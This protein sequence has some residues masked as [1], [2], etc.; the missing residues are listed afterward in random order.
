MY[1]CQKK[2]KNRIWAKSQGKNI[3]DFN[4]SLSIERLLFPLKSKSY[5]RTTGSESPPDPEEWRLN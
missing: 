1:K 2:K 5:V 4:K 3:Y